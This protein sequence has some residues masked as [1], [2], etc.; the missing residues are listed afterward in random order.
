MKKIKVIQVG[1]GPIG[2]KIV[3]YMLDRECIEIVAAVDT[4]SDKA[5][6]D[7]ADICS[8]D[9]KTGIIISNNL[10]SAVKNIKPDV[11]V[12]TTVSSFRKCAQQAEEIVKHRI[13]VVST[14]EEMLYPWKTEPQ[15]AKQLDNLAKEHNV[16]VL[17]TGVNPGFLMDFLPIVMTGVCRDVQSIKVSRLQDATFRRIPFQQKI[18]VGLTLEEFEA[19]K[20]TGTLRHVG[21]TESMQMI[22]AAMGWK[23]ESTEDILSPI[24]AEK[25]ITTGY[26]NVQPSM[27]AGVQQIGKGWVNGKEII[28]LVF[29]ASVGEQ[30]PGD[31]IE[32]KG[33]PDITSTIK[34]GVN[35]DVATCAITVNAIKSIKNASPGLR[36]MTD[37]P[38][39]SFFND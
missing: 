34:G 8:V 19:K 25:E 13:N 5:G 27:A 24:V 20:Q 16:S 33:T 38:T 10:A 17:G 6:K 36:T 3:Q 29:K 22:A 35:G 12:L 31:I 11:A 15:L 9:E 1:L 2:Q 39:V 7:L 4:A 14:C 30:N 37:I 21:L 28:T 23:L 32:I 26:K 18:G